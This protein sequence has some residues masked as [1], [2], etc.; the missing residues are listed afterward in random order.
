MNPVRTIRL[1]V[2]ADTHSLFDPAIMRHFHNVNHIVHAGDIGK[3]S[4]IDQL[5]TIAPVTAVSGNVDEYEKSGFPQ[6]TVI[7]L[8]GFKIVIRHILY[9]SGKL[10]QEGR[11]FLDRMRPDIC[12]FGHTHQPKNE[13]LGDRLLFNPGSA[14]PKRFRL[15]RGVGVIRIEHGSIETTLIVL[16]DRVRERAARRRGQGASAV[17]LLK[18][19]DG[20]RVK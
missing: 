11:A 14:G 1:G 13:W 12:I 15:Q 18:F 6:E 20:R 19:R 7:E 16:T 4:V 17:C 2:I 8:A 10:T 9:E 5:A 3:R